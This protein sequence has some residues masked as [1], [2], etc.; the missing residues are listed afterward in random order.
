MPMFKPPSG[1]RANTR[2]SVRLGRLAWQLF[3]IAAVVAIFL[4]PG[5]P[6][7]P[8]ATQAAPSEPEIPP[9]LVPVLMAGAAGAFATIRRVFMR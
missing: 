2:A 4:A 5:L 6:T 1:K 9:A 7:G 8:H 3:L